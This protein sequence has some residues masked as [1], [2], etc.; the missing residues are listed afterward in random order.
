MD[1]S[2]EILVA[3]VEACKR[4][5]VMSA[6]QSTVLLKKIMNE[7]LKFSSFDQVFDL[8]KIKK[9]SC[10][11][12]IS[13]VCRLLEKGKGLGIS[14]ISYASSYYPNSMRGIDDAPPVIYVRGNVSAL[15]ES[16]SVS[17]VGSRKATPHGLEIARRISTFLS[18]NFFNVV[19]GLAL[20]IDAA[21]HEGALAGG[22]RTV[23]VLAHGLEKAQPLANTQ[24]AARIIESDGAWISEHMVD[25]KP[26]PEY[27]VLRNRMQVGLSRASIIVEGEANSGSR[28]QAD[29]CLR[30]R[31]HL[32]AVLPLPGSKVRL[33][34]E[35]AEILVNQRGATAI[36]SKEDY[37]E[38][39][40]IVSEWR[41]GGI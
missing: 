21:A 38:L 36:F 31:R 30:N 12:S 23:A 8:A 25:V 7:G 13:E 41:L 35:L 24:L 39:L 4:A 9:E 32:F 26:R 27:F 40:R 18:D 1:D 14:S 20:G 37:P 10:N 28:T 34:S 11:A 6:S 3:V 29:F 5:K 15:S 16:R 2:D 22:G 19:S 33:L 17:V